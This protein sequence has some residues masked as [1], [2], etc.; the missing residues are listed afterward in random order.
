[1]KTALSLKFVHGSAALGETEA[2][3]AVATK[4]AVAKTYPMNMVIN[5]ETGEK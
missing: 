1:M 5:E 2:A 4:V 3:T